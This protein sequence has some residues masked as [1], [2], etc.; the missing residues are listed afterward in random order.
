MKRFELVRL[1]LAEANTF[2]ETHHRHHRP[3][4]GHIA[5]MLAWGCVPP[6]IGLLWCVGWLS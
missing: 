5:G 1:T 6:T 3:V 2:V 4:Q